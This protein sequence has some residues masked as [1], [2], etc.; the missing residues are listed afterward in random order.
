MQNFKRPR[1]GNVKKRVAKKYGVSWNTVSTW[2]KNKKKLLT[3]LNKK[4]TNSKRQKLRSGDFKKVDKIVYTW[5][6]RKRS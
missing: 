2:V 1:K 5:F 3:S 4:G 6:I